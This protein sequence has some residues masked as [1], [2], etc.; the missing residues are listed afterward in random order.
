MNWAIGEGQEENF[1]TQREWPVPIS[2]ISG[3]DAKKIEFDRA[4]VAEAS[5]RSSVPA[6]GKEDVLFED[7]WLLVI[8][9]PSGVYS[10]HVL[11]SVSQ[12]LDATDDSQKPRHLHLANRLDRDTSGVLV[13]TKC[14]T[15]AGRLTH[16]FEKRQVHKS[17][18]GLCIGPCPGWDEIVV[19]S[20]HGRSR[21]GAWRV[22]AKADV[23]RMLPD[24]ARVRDMVTQ[25]KVLSVNGN[26]L[27]KSC[28]IGDGGPASI[29]ADV[30]QVISSKPLNLQSDMRNDEVLIR[31]HP[32][33]GRTHQIRLHCQFLG[34]P[35][36]G[37]V[38]Y[39]G[40]HVWKGVK[41][42]AHSLHAESM[43]FKHPITSKDMNF[44]APFP[45]WV[46]ESC[47]DLPSQLNI[48][49]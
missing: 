38:K 19:E 42:N 44:V 32:F 11:A 33:T 10:G 34:L 28:P 14:R 40:H 8:N 43:I 15:A 1:N 17:Y 2:P 3:E 45:N 9:K 6:F 20:G 23:G 39:G 31:V 49:D 41:S 7:E 36:R 24:K 46:I 18:I 12:I 29:A 5:M 16:M 35:L 26:M 22:Y 21:W 48:V 27:T 37:D 47:K 4:M 13:V 30:V 25:F